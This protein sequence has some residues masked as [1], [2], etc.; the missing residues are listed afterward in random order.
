MTFKGRV[1][2][3]ILVVFNS[4]LGGPVGPIRRNTD[5][6]DGRGWGEGV[7]RSALIR[8]CVCMCVYKKRCYDLLIEGRKN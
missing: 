7:K 4:Q 3:T 5:D 6:M 1:Y 2:V 8:V